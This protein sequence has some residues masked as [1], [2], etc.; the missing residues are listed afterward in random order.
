M[1]VSSALGL[2]SLLPLEIPLMFLKF[3]SAIQERISTA[4]DRARPAAASWAD[5][6]AR[7]PLSGRTAA[8][9]VASVLK[10]NLLAKLLFCNFF[11]GLINKHT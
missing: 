1:G 2:G 10:P 5:I 7:K 3:L 11:A 6:L 9:R 8:H 4:L